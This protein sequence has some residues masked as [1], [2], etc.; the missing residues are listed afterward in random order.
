MKYY[1]LLIVLTI[2]Y[3]KF[4]RS[5]T[6][7]NNYVKAAIT[8]DSVQIDLL[9][10]KKQEKS[11][12]TPPQA[13]LLLST[14]YISVPFKAYVIV[15][16]VIPDENQVT[17]IP[18]ISLGE[19]YPFPVYNFERMICDSQP[20]QLTDCIALK[21]LYHGGKIKLYEFLRQNNEL[22]FNINFKHFGEL[23]DL[24]ENFTRKY[25]ATKDK[26]IDEIIDFLLKN[27]IID[28]FEKIFILV[29]LLETSGDDDLIKSGEEIFKILHQEKKL[30][31][32]ENLSDLKHYDKNTLEQDKTSVK[33]ILN[34]LLQ[35][36]EQSK[37]KLSLRHRGYQLSLQNYEIFSDIFNS[38][39]TLIQ[40][41]MSDFTKIGERHAYFQN[42]L[43]K[44][45]TGHYAKALATVAHD[46]N[47]EKFYEYLKEAFEIGFENLFPI[48]GKK[49]Q[50]YK[51]IIILA[52]SYF[53]KDNTKITYNNDD[54]DD[55]VL[56]EWL[57]FGHDNVS[58]WNSVLRPKVSVVK[59][60]IEGKK[61]K[62]QY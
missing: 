62:M 60:I 12:D 30:I 40:K 32:V 5:G 36:I 46:F 61:K 21:D 39:T 13:L 59:E 51:S 34:E 50:N 9:T 25:K 22:G 44:F 38:F 52:N 10:N 17:E 15:S 7:V 35:K 19:N 55:D 24:D 2:I 49:F 47:Q 57:L 20:N 8:F 53:E 54:D 3:S 29:G 48:N 37:S 26:F 41:I 23:V 1:I 27:N 28:N 43:K 16:N 14:N 6:R 42:N 58:A 31:K 45:L 4:L 18:S 33:N 11:Q 56:N